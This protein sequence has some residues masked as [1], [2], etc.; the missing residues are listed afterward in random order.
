[1]HRLVPDYSKQKFASSTSLVGTPVSTHYFGAGDAWSESSLRGLA[2]EASKGKHC[3]VG[4][5]QQR[6]GSAGRVCHDI[7]RSVESCRVQSLHG[8]ATR[9]R[10]GQTK[11]VIQR[12]GLF[13]LGKASLDKA[14][15]ARRV[16]AR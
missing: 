3:L 12:H 4:K 9:G 5:G 15:Q 16:I 7:E 6:H 2:G 1:M 8:I 11:L 14:W 10:L 13:G